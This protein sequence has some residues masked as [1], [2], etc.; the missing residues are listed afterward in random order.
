MNLK[1]LVT[2]DSLVD[3][4]Y[5]IIKT[6]KD[7]Y[8]KAK[9]INSELLLSLDDKN[10]FDFLTSRN[11]ENIMSCVLNTLYK[12]SADKVYNE[13]IESEYNKII[14]RSSITNINILSQQYSKSGL[15]DVVVICK[16]KMEEQFIK[17]QIKNLNTVVCSD[18]SMI[19]LSD[20][21]SIFVK[22]CKSLLEFSDING[23]V[24]YL[25]NY[26]INIE[27]DLL[28]DIVKN[29]QVEIKVV[30]VY[31]IDDNNKIKG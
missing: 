5:G 7:E 24:I 25:S 21:G 9:Y 4:D 15:I 22:S 11:Q 2:F 27:S 28:K 10:I 3:T 1:I 16:N 12:N 8:I 19:D 6:L 26:N 17:S 23:K 18:Y 30:D 14:T 20:Y 31:N 13:L 29:N